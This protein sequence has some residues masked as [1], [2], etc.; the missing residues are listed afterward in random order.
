MSDQKDNV[1]LDVL[2]TLDQH[3]ADRQKRIA[4]DR[5]DIEHH[6]NR[7]PLLEE[8]ISKYQLQVRNWQVAKEALERL[9]EDGVD[10]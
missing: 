10:E 5:D 9:P 3:I 2:S 8:R 4:S 6:K 1:I 7:I